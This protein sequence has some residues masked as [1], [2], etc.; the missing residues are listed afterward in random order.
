MPTITPAIIDSH[1]NPGIAGSTRGVVAEDDVVTVCVTTAVVLTME[2]EIDVL[3]SVVV[4]V[5]A[6]V[7]VLPCDEEEELAL[8][9]VVLL[10]IVNVELPAVTVVVTSDPPLPLVGG[11][12]GSK[13]NTPA[14]G[15]GGVVIENPEGPAP[16]AQPSCV[17]PG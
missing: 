1:G 9:E 10:V 11:F 14:S 5:L 8:L 7:T 4:A 13:W 17:L 3:I 15:I 12:S 16:T 2:V 6:V